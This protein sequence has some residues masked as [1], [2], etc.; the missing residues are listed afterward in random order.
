MCFGARPQAPQIVYQGPSEAD[1]AAN[2]AAMETYRQQSAAQQE[3][4]AAQLQQQID[5]ANAQMEEQRSRLQSEE[6]AAMA[7]MAAQ[8]QGAYAA[9]ATQSE[10]VGAA[11][12][13]TAAKPKEKARSSLK[14]SPGATAATSGA[15]LNI[16]V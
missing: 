8:Q 5:R 9:T 12:T 7:E 11:M 6:Q 1:I 15:G 16:G 3:Q 10:P 14:I 13:T 2:R 4:F